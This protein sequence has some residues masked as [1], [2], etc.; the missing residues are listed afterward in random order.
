M[1]C[2]RSR[3]DWTVQD[4]L[5]ILVQRLGGWL[6]IRCDCVDYWVPEDRAYMLFLL[7]PN[8]QRKPE[9]DY[10]AAGPMYKP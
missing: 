8:L 10:L 2:Y 7:D 3:S 6:S 4:P 9:L 5:S 1:P